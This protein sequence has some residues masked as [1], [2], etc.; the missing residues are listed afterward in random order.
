GGLFVAVVAPL[1]FKNYSEL[2]AGLFALAALVAA[3][4]FVDERS[5]LRRGRPAW[6]WGLIAAALI[7]AGA[8][9]YHDARYGVRNALEVTRNFYGVLRV[10]E[11]YA[12]DPEAHKLMLQHGGTTH[13]LQ[14]VEPHKRRLPTSYYTST[15]GIGR[16]MKNLRPETPRRVGVVGLGTGSMAVWGKPGD[17]FRFYEINEEVLRLARGRFWYVPDS[18]ANI[19]VILGDA[20]LSLE[21]EPPQNFDVLVLDAF[22]SDAIPI[23]LLTREALE[24]YLRHMKPDGVIAVHISNRYLDLQPIVLRLA[25]HFH[26]ATGIIDDADVDERQDDEETGGAYASDWVLL[27]KNKEFLNSKPILDASSEPEAFS[28]KI[29]MWTDEESNLWRIVMW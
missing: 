2:H 21:R 16:T 8:G 7:G 29:K 22:S 13:G 19:E 23:H 10:N 17:T 3:V 11:Y 5:P 26:L 6:A 20:R 24:I 4:L 15:S 27:S 25:Q 9:L 1:I 28:E 18:Q 14:F 12:S